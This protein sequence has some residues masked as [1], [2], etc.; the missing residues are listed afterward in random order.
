MKKILFRDCIRIAKDKN[1]FHPVGKY[2]KR[3]FSFLIQDNKIVEIGFN[4]NADP[5]PGY[6]S[7]GKIHS[8]NDVYRKAKGIMDFS[9]RWDL[10]NVKM[11]K[12]GDVC[13]SKPCKCC[14]N[15]LFN[16]GCKSV[17]FTNGVQGFSRVILQE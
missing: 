7:Y 10:I 15:F 16:L 4:R 12:K 13:I 2:S 3:H 6:P 9:R 14:C 5:L 8:E 1:N 17:W 11:N